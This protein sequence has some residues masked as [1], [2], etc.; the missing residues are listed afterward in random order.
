MVTPHVNFTWSFIAG[1][2][3]PAFVTWQNGSDSAVCFTVPSENIDL[4][5]LLRLVRHEL[6]CHLYENPLFLIYLRVLSGP[7]ALLVK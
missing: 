7:H 4:T 6:H 5:L 1:P 3:Q 2:I